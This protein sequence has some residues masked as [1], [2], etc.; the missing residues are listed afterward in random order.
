MP[1]ARPLDSTP[2]QR[3]MAQKWDLYISS[4]LH[5]TFKHP[6]VFKLWNHCLKYITCV[7]DLLSTKSVFVLNAYCGLITFYSE[8]YMHIFM[9]SYMY[10]YICIRVYIHIYTYI[11]RYI[12]K[13]S[14]SLRLTLGFTRLQTASECFKWLQVGSDPDLHS[15]SDPHSDSDFRF[16]F[17]FGFRFRCRFISRC[18]FRVRFPIQIKGQ[19]QI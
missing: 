17:R 1:T 15:D 18:R 16:R 2:G 5:V 19:M 3:Q 6:S 9:Y 14:C 12:F 8:K 11:C 13:T 4:F 7:A 10:I